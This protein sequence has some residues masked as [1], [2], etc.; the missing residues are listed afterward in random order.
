M[1]YRRISILLLL[2]L[3]ISAVLSAC[4]GGDATPT[5]MFPTAEGPAASATSDLNPSQARE[6]VKVTRVVDGD[7]IEVDGGRLVRY[8]GINAPAFTPYQEEAFG[9]EAYDHNKQL[10]E[11]KTVELEKDVSDTD[12]QGR[13]LR[14]VFV[15]GMFVNAEMVSQG[16]AKAQNSQ[17]DLKYQE[18]FKT[19]QNDAKQ[20]KLGLWADEQAA[21]T[22]PADAT[23]TPEEATPTPEAT[24][25]AAKTPEATVTPEKDKTP[26]PTPEVSPTPEATPTPTPVATPSEEATGTDIR[27]GG[28]DK[29]N[30]VVTLTNVGSNPANLQGWSILSVTSGQTFTFSFSLV[31]QPGAAVN[32]WT[33]G[34]GVNGSN[35]YMGFSGN[36]WDMPDAR[37][38]LYS[39]SGTLIDAAQ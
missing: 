9:R 5:S 26:T 1:S 25:E 23:A 12:D 34:S 17:V 31:L 6:K 3:L 4:G 32:V 36:L 29:A 22:T 30:E 19:L 27:I 20:A 2:T 33:H 21:I 39:P 7:T 18:M 28:L 37:C 10:V 35:V 24:E 38:E 13:L 16:F 8:L 15:D 14:Y 11:G